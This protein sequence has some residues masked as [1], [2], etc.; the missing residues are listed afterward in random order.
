MAKAKAKPAAE[1]PAADDHIA[2][3]EAALATAGIAGAHEPDLRT[4]RHDQIRV[5]AFNPRKHFDQESLDELAANI[6]EHGL[7][8]NLVVRPTGD[9]AQ[10]LGM[11]DLVAGE[12]RFR[13]I[14]ILIADGRWAPERGIH[15][16]VKD[17]DEAQHR[18]LALI[19]NLQRKD[20]R[21]LEEADGFKELMDLTGVGTAEIAAKVGFTQ[22][23]VQQRLQLLELT[24]D[25]KA[26]LNDGRMTIEQARNALANRPVKR[27][28]SDEA[29]LVFLEVAHR[30]AVSENPGTYQDVTIDGAVAD[31]IKGDE[32]PAW[33]AELYNRLYFS[34]DHET[35]HRE[36]QLSYYSREILQDLTGQADIRPEPILDAMNVVRERLGAAPFN[37]P[38]SY[39]T[40]WLNPPFHIREQDKMAAEEWVASRAR[41]DA[42]A[43]ERQARHDAYLANLANADAR[44]KALVETGWTAEP[45]ARQQT[46]V[47]ILAE[48]QNPLPWRWRPG[49]NP[50][51]PAEF[52]D[53]NGQ[54][55]NM[56]TTAAQLVMLAAI[57]S[58]GG[59]APEIIPPPMDDEDDSDGEGVCRFCGCSEDDPCV[60][61]LD[62]TCGWHCEGVCD[63]PE[64]VA[65]YEAEQRADG[66]DDAPAVDA[67]EAETPEAER[68]H[69]DAV[70]LDDTFAR[71]LRELRE[72]GDATAEAEET[73][74]A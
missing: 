17:L 3:A 28:W 55:V 36:V 6:A 65:A 25:Q 33:V 41:Q 38:E 40:P 58:L 35:G 31:L 23:F 67:D 49:P 12:R 29:A 51:T 54:P 44:A 13:A 71:Q 56:R 34:T 19:E 1:T 53:A 2:A 9:E 15:C 32:P 22:R 30:V 57:N 20:L 69:S 42:A 39:V 24:D 62:N 7:L 66:D 8:E 5:G 4:L 45:E 52:V 16:L 50:H 43:A 63:N 68:P 11:F 47:A 21:P 60:D 70:P 59:H 48:A 18:A 27:E 64:C 46:A 37:G 14:A 26:R 72:D 73:A 61:E 74:E 10:G